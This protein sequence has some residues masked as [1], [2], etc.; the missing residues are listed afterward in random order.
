MSLSA[1]PSSRQ[2]LH[3]RDRQLGVRPAATEAHPRASGADALPHGGRW[4]AALGVAQP[5]VGNAR[6]LDPKVDA[7]H[8]RAGDPAAISVH[9]VR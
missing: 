7:V 8:D 5:L 9:G 2:W 4:L 1:S 3:I 6:D